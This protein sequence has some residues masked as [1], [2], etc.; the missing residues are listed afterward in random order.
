VA[1]QSKRGLGLLP[2]GETGV[3]LPGMQARIALV[4]SLT[5]CL[6]ATALGKPKA[7]SQLVLEVTPPTAEV[8]VDG[9]NMGKASKDRAIDV[10]PGFH[11]VKLVLKGDEHEERIKFAAGDKTSYKYEFDQST[12]TNAPS[13]D[14]DQP[15]SPDSP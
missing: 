3:R 15:A 10:T 7:K 8:F 13:N 2:P 9:H 1:L 14:V 11:V 6:A 12:S 5:L 4:A